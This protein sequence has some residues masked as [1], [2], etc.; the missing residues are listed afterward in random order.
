V[1]GG[2]GGDVHDEGVPSHVKLENKVR[3]P[4]RKK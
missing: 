4:R 3:T 2:E 1:I